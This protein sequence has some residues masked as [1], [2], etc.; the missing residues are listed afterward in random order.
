MINSINSAMQM[1]A[2]PKQNTALTSE[3]KEKAQDI[4]SNFSVDELTGDDALSIVESFKELGISPGKELEQLMAYNGFDAKSIGDMA[5]ENGADMPP[6]R[7]QQ[8]VSSSNELVS[9]LEELLENLEGDLSE[10]DKT[11]ILSA[12]Q[13]KFGLEEKDSIVDVKA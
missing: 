10:D 5:R 6:P 3:Q 11:S 9:F 4:L 8:S 12:V 7:P 13:D 1:P 2:M